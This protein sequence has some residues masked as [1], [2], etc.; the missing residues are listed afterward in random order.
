MESVI[1]MAEP[2]NTWQGIDRDKIEWAPQ[3]DESLCIGC[4]LCVTTCGR[5]V[6]D[7]DFERRKALTARPTAC[8]VGCVTCENLCPQKAIGFPPVSYIAHLIKENHVLT[9]AKRKLE[10]MRVAEGS[11]R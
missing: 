11:E 7:Y 5:K 3:V 10:E 2:S 9:E 1:R 6:F 4:G 8:M